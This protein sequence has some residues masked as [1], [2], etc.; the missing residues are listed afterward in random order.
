MCIHVHLQLVLLSSP[1]DGKEPEVTVGG[2][3]PVIVR[4]FS[5]QVGSREVSI[6]AMAGV[7]SPGYGLPGQWGLQC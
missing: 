6:V 4:N 1:V 5:G 7:C 3:S 2:H